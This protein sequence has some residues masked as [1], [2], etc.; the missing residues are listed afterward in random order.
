MK[1]TLLFKTD[2]YHTFTKRELVGV[3]TNKRKLLSVTKKI[4][5]QDIEENIEDCIKEESKELIEWIHQFLFE[6][7]QTQ[8]LNSFELVIE[9]VDTNKIF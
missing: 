7:K 3:F 2:F 8:G 4:I 6:K 9:E 5:K 1:A